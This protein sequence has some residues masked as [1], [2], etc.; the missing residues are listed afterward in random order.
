[1]LCYQPARTVAAVI[2]V[3]ASATLLLF[4]N[5][6]RQGVLHAAAAYA[7]QGGVHFW[8]AHRGTEN[9]VRS[10]SFLPLE[11]KDRIAA[12]PGIA[13]AAPILRV[14][15]RVETRKAAL[16][17]LG[18]GYDPAL[19][20]GGP[21]EI[22][23][24]SSQLGRRDLV[25]DRGAAHRLG[26]GVGDTVYVNGVGARVRGLSTGTNL[27]ATQLVFGRLD[28]FFAATGGAS[29]ASFILVQLR[30]PAD[31]LRYKEWLAQQDTAIAVFSRTTFVANNV[32]EV[33]AGF[34]QVFRVL[35]GLGALIAAAVVAV[36]LYGRVLERRTQFAALLALGG[37][38]RFLRRVVL[39]QA[40]GLTL[41]GLLLAL[42][43]TVTA[44][45]LVN[46]FVPEIAFA[47]APGPM[48]A[49]ATLVFAV[50]IAGSYLPLK[51]L[52]L[53]EPA[54]VFRA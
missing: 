46:R 4:L 36:I 1:M 54:E 13:V 31:T 23:A 34:E 40:V 14:F 21:P 45:A 48:T 29:H 44:A 22:V 28:D 18:I 52:R 26:V 49:S 41:A 32:R 43:F 39:V 27:L 25:L 11:L 3:A 10:S 9:L 16:T 15:V 37:T 17:L 7:G 42:L 47:M 51:Q 33:N 20:L 6:L 24:G 8:L 53:I 19:G 35:S 38:P 2:G 12:D 30:D 50:A 5:G